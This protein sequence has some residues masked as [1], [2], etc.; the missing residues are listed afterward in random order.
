MKIGLTFRLCHLLGILLATTVC[1]VFSPA[2]TA[3][4]QGAFTDPFTTAGLDPNFTNVSGTWT[5]AAA[6]T[7]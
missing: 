7:V 2:P 6:T 4:A 1:A 5:I 3:R